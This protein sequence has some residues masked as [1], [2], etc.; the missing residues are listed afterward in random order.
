MILDALN[1]STYRQLN[2]TVKAAQEKEITIVNCLGQRYI[3][4]AVRDKHIIIRG[5]AGN[6][7]GFYLDGGQITV[8]GNAQDAVADTMNAGKIVIHGNC[9]DAAG[10][11]MRGGTVFIKGDVGYRA[12]IHMKAYKEHFP[13]MVIGGRAG[14][15]LAEYQAGGLIIVLGLCGG[16]IAGYYSGSGMHGG[17]LLLRTNK[18]P[19]GLSR[20]VIAREA[21][22]D[23]LKAYEGYIREFCEQ[24]GFDYDKVMDHTFY[25]ISASTQ[26]PYKQL[27]TYN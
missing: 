14:S 2:D 21:A 4:C 15:F 6:G 10:Y 26:Q 17:K 3:G 22:P 7:A 24:F 20:Q 23:D 11:G 8:Y 18:L 12:G 27:Y 16:D 5:T 19:A 9:G 13:V 25:E 1:F